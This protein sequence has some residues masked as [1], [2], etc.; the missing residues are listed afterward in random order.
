MSLAKKT[1]LK[2]HNI[3]GVSLLSTVNGTF[4]WR[5][6]KTAAFVDAISLLNMLELNT[7]MWNFIGH[8]GAYR[9]LPVNLL[10]SIETNHFSPRLQFLSLLMSILSHWSHVIL[11]VNTFYTPVFRRGVLWYGTVRPSVR[12]SVRLLARKNIDANGGFFSNFVHRCA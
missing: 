11:C 10:E 6:L 12:P 1:H 4:H 3:P 9:H 8:L 7:C 2:P 5:Q